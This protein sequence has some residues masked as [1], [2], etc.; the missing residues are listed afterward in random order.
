[1]E[2]KLS[3]RL[4][5]LDAA[6]HLGLGERDLVMIRSVQMLQAV[7]DAD[8]VRLLEV[9]SV[10]SYARNQ[11]IFTQGDLADRFFIV[12]DGWARVYR[13]LPDGS[14]VTINLFTDG[15]SFAE[16]AVFD[17][18]RYPASAVSADDSRFLVVR[19]TGFRRCLGESPSLAFAM[20]ASMA[21]KLHFLVRQVEQLSHRTTM[22]RVAAFLLTL[23]E[24]SQ[25]PAT[26][27][28]PIDKHLIAARLGMQPETFSRALAK[29]RSHG[30]VCSGDE[31]TIES[32]H[33]LAAICGRSG[34]TSTKS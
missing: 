24:R 20:M 10:R 31:I 30:V 21:R 5:H 23:A 29:L 1:M 19:G 9:A 8:L 13:S 14:E 7:S 28:L 32:C 18:G 34:A 26:I 33:I 12:L 6:A 3:S 16:A 22:Q 2:A 4:A 11:T 15:E 17:E 27:H 25:G